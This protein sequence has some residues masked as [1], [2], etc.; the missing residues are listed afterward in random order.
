MSGLPGGRKLGRQEQPTT[1]SGGMR[2]NTDQR[3]PRVIVHKEASNQQPNTPVSGSRRRIPTEGMQEKSPRDLD[4]NSQRFVFP[5]RSPL[6]KDQR[7]AP[8]NEQERSPLG[9]KQNLPAEPIWGN[10]QNFKDFS[11]GAQRLGAPPEKD[12]NKNCR[13]L[14]RSEP[15]SID[16]AMVKE[17]GYSFGKL[18]GNGVRGDLMEEN[19]NE[20]V[21]KKKMD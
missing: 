13:E 20:T 3:S 15:V 18:G 2:V 19:Y 14:G 12:T 11:A 21:R 17:T 4:G 9:A 16:K 10:K 6:N 7:G 5:T 8:F 1:P